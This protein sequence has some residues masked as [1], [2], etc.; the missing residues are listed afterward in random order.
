MGDSKST[1][2][3]KHESNKDFSST[4]GIVLLFYTASVLSLQ[5]EGNGDNS[6]LGE[7]L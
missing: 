6:W 1:D 7:L 4:D 2:I 5:V 3:D